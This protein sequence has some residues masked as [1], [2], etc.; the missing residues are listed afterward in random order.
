L[1]HIGVDTVK[2]KGEGFTALVKVGDKVK[3]GQKLIEFN[4]ELVKQKAKSILTPVIITNMDVVA[5]IKQTALG[6]DIKL[7]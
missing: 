4:L 3:L 1:I 6:A 5:S 7:K 2:M